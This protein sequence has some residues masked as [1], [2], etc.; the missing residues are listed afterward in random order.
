VRLFSSLG[1]VVAPPACEP[2]QDTAATC[3]PRLDHL[4]PGRPPL[5]TVRWPG[6]TGLASNL[7]GCLSLTG[8]RYRF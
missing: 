4:A 2:D 6:A 5:L 7:S 8:R 1:L 3:S